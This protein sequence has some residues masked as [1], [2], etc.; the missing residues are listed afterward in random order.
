MSENYTN[1]SNTDFIWTIFGIIV[2]AIFIPALIVVPF[3]LALARIFRIRTVMVLV[4]A[5][6]LLVS[7]IVFLGADVDIFIT[8]YVTN[9]K[10]AWGMICDNP[11]SILKTFFTY[12]SAFSNKTW[13]L[14]ICISFFITS[15]FTNKAEEKEKRK[16]A[17][18]LTHAE[19]VQEQEAA[20][21]KELT[22]RETKKLTEQAHPAEMTLLG[23]NGGRMILVPD[24]ARHIFIAGTTGSGK[25]VTIA[26]FFESALQKNY[27]LVAVDGKGD[28]GEGSMLHYL[29][30]LCGKY[31][32]ELTVVD[33]TDAENSERYN[34]F[35]N[36]SITEVKDMLMQ[37]SDWTEPHYKINTERYLQ[38][39]ILMMNKA[40]IPISLINVAKHNSEEFLLLSETL[41]NRKTI[42]LAEHEQNVEIIKTAGK[43]ANAA[44]ARFATT[45]EAEEGQIFDETGTDIYSN[46]KQNKVFLLILDPL[47]KKELS[48]AVGRLAVIDAKKAISKIFRDEQK[49][50][51]FFIFDEFNVYASEAVVDLVNKSRSAEITSILAVQGLFD[52]DQAAGYNFRNQVLENCNNYIVMRQNTAANAQEWARI[53]GDYETFEMSYDVKKEADTLFAE[54]IRDTDRQGSLMKTRKFHYPAEKIQNQKT[55]QAIFLSRDTQEHAQINV[56]YIPLT[57]PIQKIERKKKRPLFEKENDLQNEFLDLENELKN[58]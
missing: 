30:E 7:S 1:N 19:A 32:R 55:G 29:Q 27:G 54:G 40:E 12:I 41:E 10:A 6:V 5:I 14:N 43:I 4:I 52:L 38:R 3:I 51:S 42:T 31:N 45:A 15:F 36:S 25:T 34:P 33:L 21:I 18:I 37:M 13:Y 49:K 16:K 22:K 47:S 48:A 11:T 57:T 9:S 2:G 17:G 53:L 44:L 24:C 26:N 28:T 58:L 50:R 23:K 46:L 39:L 20:K 56:R 8:E 35:Q